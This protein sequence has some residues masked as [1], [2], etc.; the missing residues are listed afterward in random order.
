[1]NRMF[2][3]LLIANRGEIARRIIRTARALGVRTILAYSEAD[4]DSPALAEADEGICLGAAPAKDSYLNMNAMIAACKASRAEALHPGFGFLAE[5]ADFAEALQ[6]AGIVFIGPSP[7]AMRQL[8]DKIAAKKIAHKIGMPLVPGFV[9]RLDSIKNARQEAAKI[10]YPIIL[11][12]AAGGGGR[13]M[14]IVRNE[15][16]IE[17]AL[18]LASAEAGN[19]F[20][21]ARVFLERFIEN[22]KHIEFQ[23]L[24]DQHG[25]MLHLGERECSLQRRHQK[26]IEEAPSPSLSEAQREKM[27]ALSVRLAQAAGYTSAGTV[28]FMLDASGQFYFLEMN[29]RL[30]VEHPVTEAITG[31]DLVEWQLRIA[32]GEK[33]PF[34]QKEMS[35]QIKKGGHAIEARLCAEDAAQNFAPSTG[36]ITRCLLPSA[37]KNLRMESGISEGVRVTPYYDSML[38]KL[39]AHAASRKDSITILT[40]ALAAV[41][42]Q[43]IAH[44]APFLATLL[45][46]PEFV[47]ASF[48]TGLIARDYANGFHETLPKEKEQKKWLALLLASLFKEGGASEPQHYI[49][50]LPPEK[51]DAKPRWLKASAKLTKKAIEVKIESTAFLLQPP[52]DAMAPTSQNLSG[53]IGGKT[54]R[55]HKTWLNKNGLHDFLLQDGLGHALRIEIYAA[56][57]AALLSYLPPPAAISSSGDILAPMPGLVVRLAVQE[58]QRVEA[59]QEL[60]RLEAMKMENIIKAASAGIVQNLKIKPGDN[61]QKSQLLLRVV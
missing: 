30:Q 4:A 31:L 2:K 21:D 13:G 49:L 27:G 36:L 18:P 53:S 12:A 58:G 8:G 57:F 10:G 35:A 40:R 52:E 1:M 44:N 7:A 28:E 60:L 20:G 11:K 51:P 26:L 46:H 17:E 54:Y 15:R 61:V 25:H 47:D 14:R 16:E 19:N 56:H 45:Q 34:R 43:G 24:A 3:T 55:L 42:L 22:P 9:G 32:A 38:C 5:N 33:L 23:I 29:T 6:K 50:K 41:D 39:I 59:G 37:A 48:T